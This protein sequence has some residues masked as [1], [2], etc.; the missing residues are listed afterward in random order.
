MTRPFTTLLPPPAQGLAVSFFTPLL[1]PTPVA[2]RLPQPKKIDDTINQFLRVEAAGGP[3]Y[4][5]YL[6]Q[7][8]IILH[9]YSTN[10]EESACEQMLGRALAHGG[11]AQGSFILHQSTGVEWYVTASQISS[12]AMKYADPAVALT[13]FRGMVTWVVAGR[14]L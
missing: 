9:A 10:N 14:A 11:N 3:Q 8:S 7:V 2:T 4:D 5:E 1:A 13:R 6:F 12:Q